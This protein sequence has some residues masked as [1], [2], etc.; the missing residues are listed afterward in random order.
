[1]DGYLHPYKTCIFPFLPMDINYFVLG[2]VTKMNRRSV[3]SPCMGIEEVHDEWKQ[4][5]RLAKKVK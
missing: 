2:C 4:K 5:V 1:M 3:C